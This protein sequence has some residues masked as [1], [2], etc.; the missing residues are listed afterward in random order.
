MATK[1]EE[2]E[3]IGAAYGEKFRAAGFDNC[4]QLLDAGRTK[5]GRGEIAQ[6]T[7]I[8]EKLIL[9]WVNHADLFRIN[10]VQGQFAQ[11]LEASG[12][13]TVKE[14]ATRNPDNLAAKMAE[15]NAEKKCSKV[16]PKADTVRGWVEE[17]KQLPPIVQY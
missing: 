12:V 10:G 3:G 4:E 14:L 6:K 11:L 1:I 5:K 15:V 16:T 8:T 7:G 17:A 9:T 13:D 2:I